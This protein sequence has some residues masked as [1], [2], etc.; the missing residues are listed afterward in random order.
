MCFSVVWAGICFSSELSNIFVIG[1]NVYCA[2]GNS[3]LSLLGGKRRKHTNY[4][5]G[6]VF[7]LVIAMCIVWVL[8]KLENCFVEYLTIF[9]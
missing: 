6:F 4:D 5:C 7:L 3:H 2:N 1:H 8:M 9:K